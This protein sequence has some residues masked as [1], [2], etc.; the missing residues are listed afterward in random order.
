MEIYT[1]GHG[2][3]PLPEFMSLLVRYEIEAVIDVRSV[4]YSKHVP[5][6]DKGAIDLEL[7]K[8]GIKYLYLADDEVG[9]CLGGRPKDPECYRG[10]VVDYDLVK[11]RPWYKLWTSEVAVYAK[12][13]R[14]ALMCAEEDPYKCHRHNLLTQTLI[15]LGVK[16]YHIRR[17][18]ILEEGKK[19]NRQVMLAS[20]F[21]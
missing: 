14:T 2:N 3:M 11:T 10:G 12:K 16:V 18:G 9:N 19:E 17:G 13:H 20:F 4:P 15:S 5:Q 21:Q 8:R 7:E 1:I 6:Y